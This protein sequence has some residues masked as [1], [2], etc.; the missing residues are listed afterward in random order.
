MPLVSKVNEAEYKDKIRNILIRRPNTTILQMVDVLATEEGT[1]LDKDYVH[2]LIR[3]LDDERM[4]RID[5]VAL[6]GAIASFLERVNAT[7]AYLW[8]ILV[9][10]KQSGRDRVMAAKELRSNY[11]EMFDV[12]FDAGIFDRKLGDININMVEALTMAEQMESDGRFKK[13]IGVLPTTGKS[14]E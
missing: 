13:Q 10:P 3:E 12:M 11:K 1:K 7:D 6:K 4:A 5:G 14:K 2:K 9:D 8:T